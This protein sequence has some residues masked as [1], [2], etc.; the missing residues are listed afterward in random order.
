MTHGTGDSMGLWIRVRVLFISG[1]MT[2]SPSRL[3]GMNGSDLIC[4]R[5][6][7]SLT[8]LVR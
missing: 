1:F 2:S 3:S 8:G 4:R 7:L 6:L 5:R